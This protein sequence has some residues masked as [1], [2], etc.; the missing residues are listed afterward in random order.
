MRTILFSLLIILTSAIGCTNSTKTVCDV[1]VQNKSARQIEECYVD[2]GRGYYGLGVLSP[3]IEAEYLYM[4]AIL[5]SPV[6]VKW[7]FAH[8][9]RLFHNTNVLGRVVRANDTIKILILEDKATGAN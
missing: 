4:P 8:G 9:R 2:C 5:D 1:S 6:Q 7:K 3:G